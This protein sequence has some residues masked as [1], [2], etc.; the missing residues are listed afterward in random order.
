[1]YCKKIYE[2]YKDQTNNEDRSELKS[3]HEYYKQFEITQA[4][5]SDFVIL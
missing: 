3:I 5:L 1:M 2:P 4:S